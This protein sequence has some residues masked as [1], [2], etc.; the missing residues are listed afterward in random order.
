MSKKLLSLFSVVFIL[1]ASIPFVGITVKAEDV[2]LE[3]AE[4]ETQPEEAVQN[5]RVEAA[6][7]W[8]VDIANDNTHGYNM[9]A[10]LGPDYDCSSLIAAA[11]KNA[12]FAVSATLD[13]A[14]LADGF[15]NAGFTLYAKED[16]EIQRGDILLRPKTADRGGHAEIYLGDDQCV[17][18]VENYDNLP[19]DGDGNEIAI[20]TKETCPFCGEEDYIYVLRYEGQSDSEPTAPMSF[21]EK[22]VAFFQSIWDFFISL[23]NGTL[24]TTGIV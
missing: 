22:V 12:G 7:Q 18:A 9:I 2:Q 15:V 3:A 5:P 10:R 4:Q 6:V 1:L 17:A 16:V 8:A 19:G 21:W 20:R 11:F 14:S 13:T 24:T 23:F